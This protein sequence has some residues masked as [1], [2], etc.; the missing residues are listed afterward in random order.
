MGISSGKS[1]GRASGDDGAQLVEFALIIPILLLL[2][3]GII[4]FG[5]AFGQ[6]LS[7]NQAAR[8]GARKAVVTK[9]APSTVADGANSIES[10]VEGAT[11]GLINPASA[12]DV[13]TQI[14]DEPSSGAFG[15][16]QPAGET[17]ADY[18]RFGGQLRVTATYQS[19]W[20]VPLLL[21][22]DAPNLTAVATFRCEVIE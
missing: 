4:N 20:L 10:F 8:E 6:Q 3:F 21:P 15:A 2:V 22:I 19:S 16:F 18:T 17:C 7:L 13:T 12:I 9:G 14:Q 5:Y 11:G 1:R